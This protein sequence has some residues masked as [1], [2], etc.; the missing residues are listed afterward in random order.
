MIIHVVQSGETIDFISN[1]YKIPVTNLINENGITNPDNLVVG[2]TIVIIYPEITYTVQNGD[3]LLEI[4]AKYNVSVMQLLRNNPYL[5]DRTYLIPGETIIISY[6]TEKIGSIALSGYAYTFIDE[7]ILRKTLPYL[8]YLNIFSYRVTKEGDIVDIDDI[9]LIQTAKMYGVA[10]MMFLSTLSEIGIG[11]SEVAYTIITNPQIQEYLFENVINMLKRKGYYG[12]N[13]YLQYIRPE[14]QVLVDEFLIKFS[15]RLHSEGFRV[16]ATVTPR[17]FIERTEIIY[18]ELDYTTIAQNVDA[19]LISSY[20]WGTS[21]GPPA[22]VT[23]VNIVSEILNHV[24]LQVSPDQV[25]LGLPI[26]NYE[27]HLPYIPG[28]SKASAISNEDAIE[29]AVAEGVSIEYNEVSQAPYYFY[30]NFDKELHIVWFKD[31]RSI[32]VITSLAP[33]YGLKGIS[34]WNIMKFFAQM[35]FIINNKFEIEKII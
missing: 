26:I 1:K 20:E 25:Y 3:S 4:A 32:D 16:V 34:I 2:Q 17:M 6:D 23:P 9:E 21:F 29:L 11:N 22:S 15:K 14:N 33:E 13:I 12:V 28:E 19:L 18:E 27:W 24:T 10:P 8:T 30:T 7:T 5:E 35:W 31:A